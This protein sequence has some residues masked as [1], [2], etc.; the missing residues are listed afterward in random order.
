MTQTN[1]QLI[2]LSHTIED[3]LITYQGLPAPIVCDF[4]SRK[5][6][7]DHYEDGTSFQIDKIEMVGN[8]GTYLDSP[9][10]RYA[11]GKDIS[12][13]SLESVA[14]LDA[15]VIN[16][17]ETTS[18]GKDLFMGL[19]LKDKAVLVHTTWS[20]HWNTDKYFKNHPHLTHDA[21]NFLKESQVKLVGIDSLNIDDIST[22][23][24][25]VHSILLGANI[26]IVEHLCH[27][28]KL[29]TTPF[30]FS[31]VPV[32]VKNVGTFPVRAFA[33]IPK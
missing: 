33:K 19:D 27:L 22:G 12:E 5:A 17:T 30:K 3:G 16:A 29:P 14:E 23:A 9:F 24:R 8:S 7:E 32:K 11:K 26:L 6:S 13:L 25:P 21:A 15:I 10:H 2:D 18:I 1:Q 31:A 28:N 4:L 20:K